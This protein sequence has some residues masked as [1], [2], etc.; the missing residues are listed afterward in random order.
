MAKEY[1]FGVDLGGT[2]IKLGLFNL[3][4]GLI[5]KWSVKTDKRNNGE[6]VISQI[7]Q[8][9]A[10]KAEEK[11][12]DKNSVLGIG[13][14]VPGPVDKDGL[15]RGCVN[16]GWGYKKAAEELQNITG[17]K[18]AVLNDADAAGLGEAVYG[19]GRKYK[20][21]VM[22]T[23]GTG[24]GGAVIYNGKVV[25]GSRG[26]A[27]EIGHFKVNINETEKC[28]CGKCGCLEYYASAVGILRFA[29]ENLKNYN[30]SLLN[31]FSDF[32]VK[33]MAECAQKGDELCLAAFDMAGKYIGLGLS[34]MEGAF[35]PDV[36][37]IGGGVSKAGDVILK[38]IKKYFDLYSF[39]T[40]S[41]TEVLPAILG[42]DAGIYGAC[43][44]VIHKED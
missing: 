3:Q 41:E 32:T 13:L 38:P 23:I 11:H 40:E 15:V 25:A 29:K 22:A 24:V 1:V 18:C 20:N 31:S 12:I 36:F 19:S 39:N 33:D 44:Y 8:E 17:V 16:I 43:E 6:F 28:T 10:K 7:A 30:N 37:V 34:Y 4:K 42:N 14:C 5:E 21:I 35:D 2:E 27:G 9:T 26:N